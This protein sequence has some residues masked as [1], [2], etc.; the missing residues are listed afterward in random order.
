REIHFMS[1]KRNNGKN[2]RKIYFKYLCQKRGRSNS[3]VH[4]IVILT[5]VLYFLF[6]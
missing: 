3:C 4:C 6:S 5:C 1:L 2:L